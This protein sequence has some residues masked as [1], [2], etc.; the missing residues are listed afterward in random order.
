MHWASVNWRIF[1]VNQQPTSTQPTMTYSLA[2]SLINAKYSF[3]TNMHLWLTSHNFPPVGPDIRTYL[4]T[5][6]QTNWQRLRSVC[7]EFKGSDLINY[8]GLG[9]L[10][11]LTTW[12]YKVHVCGYYHVRIG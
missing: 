6:K 12:I 4:R 9:C 10:F 8:M 1:L 11:P 5:Y 7:L 3:Q 2:V